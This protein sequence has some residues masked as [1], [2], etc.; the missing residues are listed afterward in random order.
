MTLRKVLVWVLDSPRR[1]AAVL[2]VISCV[3]FG[4]LWLSVSSPDE[5]G[6]ELGASNHSSPPVSHE[7]DPA[8]DDSNHGSRTIAERFLA[9]YLRTPDRDRSK[10]RHELSQITTDDLGRALDITASDRFPVGPHTSFEH[11]LEGDHLNVFTAQLPDGSAIEI[12][13]VASGTGWLVSD[14]RAAPEP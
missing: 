7:L 5:S 10:A 3:I 6:N 13:V 12:M 9:A 14:V 1:F 4:A 8:S 11:D 2:A